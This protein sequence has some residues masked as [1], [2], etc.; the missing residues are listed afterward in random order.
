[1]LEQPVP[2][3]CAI[4]TRKSTEEGLEQEF[5]TLQ[6]Q[7][8]SAEAY[9]L[10]H[11]QAGWTAVP[12][13][14]DD[15]GFSGAT[16]DRPALKKLL[17]DIEAGCINCVLVYKVD[18]LSRSLL[19]FARL[20]E[21]FDKH[22]V[23][24]VSITQDFNTTTSLG[25]LTLNVLLS[26]AQFEREIISE[27]TR[28]KLSAARRKGK[29]IG[30]APV[31]GY[32]LDP[33]RKRLVVN[34]EEARQVRDIFRIYSEVG[35][36]EATLDALVG[37]GITNKAWTSQ[38]GNSR[39]AKPFSNTGL[40]LLLSRVLY[41]GS[42]LHKGTVYPGEQEAIVDPQ[43]WDV[44]NEKLKGKSAHV[45][46]KKHSKQNA[47]LA[48]L[49]YCAQ[50]QGVMFASHTT[51]AGQ[52]HRYYVCGANRRNTKPRCPQLPVSAPD[53]ETA[54]TQQ[55]QPMLGAQLS[56]AV[57]QQSVTRVDYHSATR[58]VS[59]TMREGTRFTYTL[60]WPPRAGVRRTTG[61]IS[62]GG[63]PRMSRLMA[64]AIKLERLLGEGVVLNFVDA[65]RL[66]GISRPRI[67]QILRLTDLAPA[68]Q[69][70]LLLLPKVLP[71]SDRFYEGALR[72][73]AQVIDWQQQKEMFRSL[74]DGRSNRKSGAS[75]PVA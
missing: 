22:K 2:V 72:D 46:G 55:L 57:I 6:A 1:M 27:R 10:S 74:I 39:L 33:V 70:E 34:E 36:L 28:D 26:F 3:R 23:S 20:M 49:L 41:V 66:G 65:A 16:I 48:K 7:R 19:D 13:R 24:F 69:E 11:R 14:Y 75:G 5:N 37:Q 52:I 40:R 56:A 50:C 47:L 64:L 32:D 59:T 8:E 42:V 54:L 30:G 60:A 61:D 35:S 45:R 58:L 63:V 68:I 18:R 67:S 38:K 44:V 15:G 31:L 51:K 29:W 62:A 21:S 17:T 73:I 12:E 4:Y 9:I 43:L 71:G 53:L 25:R